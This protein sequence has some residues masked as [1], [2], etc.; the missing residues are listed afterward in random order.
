MGRLTFV[1]GTD[2]GAGKTLLTALL[3]IHLRRRGC[4]ALATKPF[5]TGNRRD[6]RILLAAQGREL[7]LDEINPYHFDLPVAPLVAARVAGETVTLDDVLG[8]IRALASRCD[9]LLIEGAGGLMVPL[10]DGYTVANLIAALR[11]PVIMAARNR[12]GVVN[13]V[14]L[15]LAF[16]QS[17]EI[18]SVRIVLMDQSRPDIA[19]KTN[20]AL[21]TESLRNFVSLQSR[22]GPTIPLMGAAVQVVRIPF[23]G[24]KATHLANLKQGAK[25]CEKTLAQ[26]AESDSF[27]IAFS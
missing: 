23:L 14:L 15:S 24:A 22:K 21:I 2:T 6:A 12:L 10:G 9:Q 1:T 5:S 7:S 18:P 16:L 3:L 17:L 25:M 26:I 11:C 4:R 8:G 20:E 13:H 19:S 27:S